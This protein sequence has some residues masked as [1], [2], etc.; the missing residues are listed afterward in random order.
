MRVPGVGSLFD[1][2]TLN[3]I[4]T[5]FPRSCDQTPEGARLAE[6]TR[7]CE[8]PRRRGQG[9]APDFRVIVEGARQPLS[10]LL[11]DEVYRIAREILRNAFH[12]AHASRIEAEIAYDANSSGCGFG[13]ME[14]AS[15]ARSWSKGRARVTGDCRASASAQN[16]SGRS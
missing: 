10:P 2:T 6:G 3:V 11:Q 14:R 9:D 15:T 8:R 13:I 12:H 7:A 5:H 16:A 4:E 1:V